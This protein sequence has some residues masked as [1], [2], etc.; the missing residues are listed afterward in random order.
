[1][2]QKYFEIIPNDFCN[3]NIRKNKK[4]QLYYIIKKGMLF[5]HLFKFKF[6]EMT[7]HDKF[8]LNKTYEID[9]SQF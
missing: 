6:C 8:Q 5:S 9:F 7:T 1:M 3:I 2:L 4:K